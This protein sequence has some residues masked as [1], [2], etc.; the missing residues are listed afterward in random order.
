[1]KEWKRIR[2]EIQLQETLQMKVRQQN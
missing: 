1:M 2:E